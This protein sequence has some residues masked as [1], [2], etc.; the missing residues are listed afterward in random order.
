MDRPSYLHSFGFLLIVTILGGMLSEIVYVALKAGGLRAALPPLVTVV[1]PVFLSGVILPYLLIRLLYRSTLRDFGILWTDPQRPWLGWFAGSS[2]LVLLVW[3]AFW[4]GL[5]FLLIFVPEDSDTLTR[6]E[7]HSRNPIYMLVNNGYHAGIFAT[8]FH[9]FVTVGF[10]EELFGRGLLQNALDRRYTRVFGR[11]RW[12]VRSSTILAALLFAFWHTEWLS[13]DPLN[14]LG[15]LALSMTV[16]LVPSILL[17]VVYE[18]TRSMLAV[19][20]LHNVID[21]GK[22]LAWYLWSLIW[23]A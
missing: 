2:A 18:K 9:W 11:G 21:G 5:C 10:A 12:T 7:L 16:V 6:A 8:V 19:I 22:L 20:L 17:S 4:G 23:P 15:S 1:L 13:P 3:F 14:I